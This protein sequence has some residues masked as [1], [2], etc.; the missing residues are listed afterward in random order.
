MSAKP[1]ILVAPLSWGLG[2]A[3]RC[4]PII[5]ALRKKGEP[6]IIGAE[7]KALALLQEEFPKMPYIDFDS[8]P[9]ITYPSGD[10]GDLKFS[11]FMLRQYKK[12]GRSIKRDQ[13][14]VLDMVGKGMLKGIISDNRFGVHH[15]SVHS[16][17]LTHQVNPI[18]PMFTGKV[19]KKN[20]RMLTPFDEV[21]IPDHEG[22]DNLTGKLT[23][24]VPFGH[25]RWIGQLSRFKK[26][27]VRK[28]D[29]KVVM[30]LSGP[31]PQ[32]SALEDLLTESIEGMDRE[33]VLVRGLPG[34]RGKAERIPELNLTVHNHLSSKEMEALLN[35]SGTIISRSGYTSLM[36]YRKLDKRAILIPTPGQTE[37]EYLAKRLD[38]KHGFVALKQRDFSSNRLSELLSEME[39]ENPEN[40]P[41]DPTA[42]SN[43]IDSFLKACS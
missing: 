15:T 20:H 4:I 37:Q 38:G 2:H 6:V 13:K 41:A 19:H 26:G 39:T 11:L 31:E 24:P 7:G 3:T 36:D 35:S 8:D 14:I 17:I 10:P 42:L 21:W 27:T 1:S 29:N 33:F 23:A 34:D 18:S 40:N 9:G 32:R 25:V 30:I 12:L 43:A 16:V 22:I 28:R 5:R